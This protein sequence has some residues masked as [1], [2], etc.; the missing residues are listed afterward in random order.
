MDLTFAYET[1]YLILLNLTSIF[2]L[3]FVNFAIW[4]KAKKI[5]LLYSYLVTQGLLLV[6]MVFKI[7]KNVAPD[8]GLKYL[9]VVLQY[10]G[11]CFLGEAFLIFAFLYLTGKLPAVKYIILM[12]IVPLLTLFLL[13]T[14]PYHSLFYSH[15]DFWGDSFG[16]VFYIHQAYNYLLILAGIFLCVKVSKS[17]FGER[18]KRALLFSIAIL[19]PL[20]A[21]IIYVFG[22]FEPLFGFWP[23]CD[24]TPI[25]CNISLMLFALAIFRYRFF[26]DIKIARRKALA[27]I[28]DA[29][30]LL[31]ADEQI[32]DFND[33]FKRLFE[34]GFLYAKE[35]AGIIKKIADNPQLVLFDPA[36]FIALAPKNFD[37]TYETETGFYYRAIRQPVIIGE[38]IRGYSLRFI[39]ITLKQAIMN[40]TENKNKMLLLLNKKL[41]E[42]TSICRNLAITRVRNLI[43]EEAHDVLGHS[44]I[45]VISI[46]EAARLSLGK[47][48]FYLKN[49]LNQAT[50]I[51][52]E[53][54]KKRSFSGYAYMA[55]D[56]R[57]ID[58]IN[59]L[60]DTAG[61]ALV[62]VELTVS[63]NIRALAADCETE[64]FRLCREGITNAIRHGKACKIDIILR[65]CPQEIMVYVIDDGIGC[66]KICKGMGIAGIEN[67]LAAIGGSLTCGSYDTQG[68]F[69]QAVIPV[70]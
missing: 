25:S 11:I 70:R 49:S 54:M 23:P 16:I 14:N 40:N 9:F 27:S 57:L 65:F 66:E 46:L 48:G 64:I 56:A 60:I 8:I 19:I 43:A 53:C 47:P 36:G 62:P 1:Y 10:V 28:P 35:E 3:I 17:Y 26:D 59:S 42:Q 37:I 52:K 12:G 29:I 61:T 24:I 39:D 18:R 2:I 7:L 69:L 34:G 5:P 51:L 31:D 30:L 63:G 33:T 45:L 21:N 32:I 4:L 15:F 50:G 13:I 68:F 44:V 67:R 55:S 58:R 20:A 41:A 38:I 6:W 22:W